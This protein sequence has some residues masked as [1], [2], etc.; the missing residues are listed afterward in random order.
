MKR[1]RNIG[2][3]PLYDP[4]ID[5]KRAEIK[6][7]QIC[8]TV[9]LDGSDLDSLTIDDIIGSIRSHF[10]YTSPQTNSLEPA[11]VDWERQANFHLCIQ[12]RKYWWNRQLAKG[13]QSRG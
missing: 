11:A 4:V 6:L 13:A 3:G 7:A 8:Y 12:A 1:T 2:D 10:M 5:L 9:G